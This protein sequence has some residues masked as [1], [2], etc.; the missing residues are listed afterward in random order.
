M[1]CYLF[2]Y[3][4]Y[5]S[6]LPD[7]K[8][9]YVERKQGILPQDQKLADQYR[10]RMTEAGKVFDSRLQQAIIVVLL[11]SQ[12][13]QCFESYAIATDSTHVH[14]LIGWRDD[15]AWLRMRSTVKGS[16]SRS[17]NQEFGKSKW[18]SEGGSRK[19]VRDR[20]HFDYLVSVYMPR[21]R[22]VKWDRER[23]FFE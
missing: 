3:H 18:L 8:R 19:R 4:A 14:A 11:D 20:E 13:K 6:W 1:P 17:L 2:T 10:E 22:G 21:H 5:G 7:R 9:G 15:R 23:G 12:E 16:I